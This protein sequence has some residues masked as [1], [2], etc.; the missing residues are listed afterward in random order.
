MGVGD[1][2]S[3]STN[4]KAYILFVSLSLTNPRALDKIKTNQAST[5][6]VSLCAYVAV[7]GSVLVPECQIGMSAEHKGDVIG[8]KFDD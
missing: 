6:L 3:G 1:E 5:M 4:H 2:G 8:I 7:L